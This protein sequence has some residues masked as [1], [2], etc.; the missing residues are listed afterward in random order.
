MWKSSV[1]MSEEEP[2]LVDQGMNFVRLMF[3]LFIL[4]GVAILVVKFW[5]EISGGV[6]QATKTITRSM[7]HG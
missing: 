4:L 3:W 7:K 5:R 2:T 1:G 6:K